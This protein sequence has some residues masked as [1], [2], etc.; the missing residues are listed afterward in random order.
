MT[1]LAFL[2]RVATML[3][4]LH[5]INA[6]TVHVPGANALTLRPASL[7]RDVLT[8]NMW[9]MTDRQLLRVLMSVKLRVVRKFSEHCGLQIT[10][11]S[12]IRKV[13]LGLCRSRHDETYASLEAVQTFIPEVLIALTPCRRPTIRLQ[14]VVEFGQL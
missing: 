3:P 5:V 8:P 4:A 13:M 14:T 12:S 6:G 1:P 10:G 2:I 7:N 11:S 9:W